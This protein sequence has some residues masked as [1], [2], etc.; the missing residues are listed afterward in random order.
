MPTYSQDPKPVIA[1]LEERFPWL[2]LN[3]NQ[4]LHVSGA[5]VIEAL[6]RAY[7]SL[8]AHLTPPAPDESETEARY[9]TRAKEIYERDGEIE[10]DA[11][12]VVSMGDDPGAY[13]AAW[14]WVAVK[15]QDGT[16]VD[17]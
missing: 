9:R 12:A 3:Q 13:V 11:D 10:I 16:N 14:V 4:D 15:E 6:E 5:D 7:K 2:T 1:F 17:A 8:F